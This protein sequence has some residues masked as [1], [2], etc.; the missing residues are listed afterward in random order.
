MIPAAPANAAAVVSA[1]TPAPLKRR[2]LSLI[3]EALILAA[4]ALTGGS[5]PSHA[6]LG[7]DQPLPTYL[8][9]WFCLRQYRQH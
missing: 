5:M 6:E 3:Y 4:I 2:L 7:L 9:L 1:T 8:M